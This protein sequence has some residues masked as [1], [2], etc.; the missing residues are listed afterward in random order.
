M[1]RETE[2]DYES[3]CRNVRKWPWQNYSTIL[4]QKLV[5]TSQNLSQNAWTPDPLSKRPKFETDL[6]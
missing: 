5:E 2:D 3:F 6:K 4:F 1:R